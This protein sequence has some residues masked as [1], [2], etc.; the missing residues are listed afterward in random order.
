MTNKTKQLWLLSGANGAGKSTFHHLFL[1]P[2]GMPMV[3]A[4]S[5]ARALSP[6]SPESASYEAAAQAE[7]LRNDLL[8]S[9]ASFCFETV[10]SHPSKVDFLARA[11]S[12]GYKIIL[13]YIHLDTPELNLLRIQQRVS[14]GGHDVPADKVRAR[15]PR[16]LQ[17]V[18]KALPLVDEARFLDNSSA[19]NPLQV[20]GTLKSGFASL[21]PTSPPP[22]LQDLL[23]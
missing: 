14:Q 17:N 2:Q 16:T 4:D 19:D 8:D 5:I 23:Q 22:W 20:V 18:K 21:P 10:F 12:L 6:S 3:N 1:E 11:K 9:G 15:L 13:V 7:I